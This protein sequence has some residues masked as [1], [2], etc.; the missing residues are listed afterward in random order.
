MLLKFV[1]LEVEEVVD[2]KELDKD[3]IETDVLYVN[4]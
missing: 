2:L 3:I 4:S 1:K